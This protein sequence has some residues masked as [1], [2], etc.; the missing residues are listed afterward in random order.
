MQQIWY[1]GE[2][3][4][5][6]EAAI[7]VTW[8][9]PRLSAAVFDGIRAYWNGDSQQLYLFRLDEHIDR[10]VRAQR[11]QRMEGTWTAEELKTA[12]L[13]VLRANGYREDVYVGPMAFLGIDT[14]ASGTPNRGQAVH[15]AIT[16]RPWS[17]TLAAP[18]PIDCGVSTWIR[19]PDHVM[20]PRI[21]C[22]ANYNNYRLAT[23]E[24]QERGHE[25][26]FSAIMMNQ[27]GKVAEGA[28]ASLFVVRDGQVITP[29][30]GAD[31]LESITRATVIQLCR[32]DMGLELIERDLDR[33]ELYIADEIW[34]CGTGSEIIPVRSVDHHQVGHGDLGTVT[35]RV[36]ELYERVVRGQDER[37]GCWRTA[38]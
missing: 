14:A 21:K 22:I 11:F 5:A 20:P 3:M 4:A 1:D 38:V 27:R 36:I 31:I 16:P 37:Y 23:L 19:I 35:S 30:I 24:V 34:Q 32:A 28:M 29:P 15:I 9:G 8:I 26:F 7:P 13:E 33:S 25:H 6:A 17:S 18:Q 10:F 2:I 12:T